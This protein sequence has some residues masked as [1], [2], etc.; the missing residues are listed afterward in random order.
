MKHEDVL[1]VMKHI[2]DRQVAN[3]QDKVFRFKAVSKTRKTR[4]EEHRRPAKYPADPS[5]ESDVPAVERPRPA[6]KTR[7]PR[8][9]KAAPQDKVGRALQQEMEGLIDFA[10]PATPTNNQANALSA[11]TIAPAQAIAAETEYDGELDGGPDPL[12]LEVQP[13]VRPNY[14]GIPNFG[15]NDEVQLPWP[16]PAED[17]NAMFGRYRLPMTPGPIEP[18]PAG[19]SP[20]DIGVI[21]PSL[22]GLR[23]TP[24]QLPT[25]RASVTP[26]LSPLKLRSD[27]SV[28]SSL[29]N[30]VKPHSGKDDPAPLPTQPLTPSAP[31]D[32][33][34][35]LDIPATHPV[36]ARVTR[37]T[38]REAAEVPIAP[39]VKTRPP[40][41]KRRRSVKAPAPVS[42]EAVVS[43][44]P[45]IDAPAPPKPRPRGKAVEVLAA[46]T[47]V[48]AASDMNQ[49]ESAPGRRT[50]DVLAAAE[51]AQLDLPAKR[52][53][54]PKVRTT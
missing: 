19:I 24:V 26:Q 42:A 44:A 12:D 6:K 30:E 34:K 16:K 13:Q 33:P 20:E 37:S 45:T 3:K 25:P 46:R 49:I 41:V 17:V 8:A 54:T 15:P 32:T 14:G 1:A 35:G 18:F 38:A 39:P 10:P 52:V 27:S 28:G 40:A 47:S 31:Q 7:K 5:E 48:T 29:R 11:E 53:R 36:G 4:D 21:D 50:A 51:A 43:A 23:A 22:I 2:V 9:K